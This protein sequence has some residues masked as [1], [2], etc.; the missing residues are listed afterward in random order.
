M[1]DNLMR[2]CRALD[3]ALRSDKP[4]NQAD[5]DKA[6]AMISRLE[7]TMRQPSC[8][9]CGDRDGCLYAP[10]DP[11]Q[12]RINCILHRAAEMTEWAYPDEELPPVGVTV[13]GEF[14]SPAGPY[15]AE[16]QYQPNGLWHQINVPVW[17]AAEPLR[18]RH[19]GSEGGH[20]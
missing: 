5:R 11:T 8:L 20:G 2:E 1:S 13:L 15:M 9:T 19:R 7:M 14:D 6:A 17:S 18:W 3:N 10:K 4:M 16:C 12:V